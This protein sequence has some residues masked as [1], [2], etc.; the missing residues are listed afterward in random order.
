MPRELVLSTNSE[1]LPVFPIFP[2]L[3]GDDADVS[4]HTGDELDPGAEPD[5]VRGQRGLAVCWTRAGALVSLGP[6]ARADDGT[7]VEV[8]GHFVDL[9]WAAVNRLVR[10]LRTARD[11]AFG[12]PE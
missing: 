1:D 4:S 7:D 10:F 8:P 6:V 9:D 2:G 3:P 12:K 11:Q 5:T